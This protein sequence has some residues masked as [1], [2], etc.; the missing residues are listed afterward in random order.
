MTGSGSCVGWLPEEEPEDGLEFTLG[1]WDDAPGSLGEGAWESDG[2]DDEPGFE[3]LPPPWEELLPWEEVEG[4]EDTSE[5]EPLL[6]WEELLGVEEEL[7]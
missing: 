4:W 6:S 2:E 5:E 1:D 3:E 7:G